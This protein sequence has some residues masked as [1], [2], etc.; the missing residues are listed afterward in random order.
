MSRIRY[1]GGKLTETVGGKYIMYADGNIEFH[2][3]KEIVFTGAEKGIRFG[4][5]KTYEY[6]HTEIIEVQFI[7]EKNKVLKKTALPKFGGITATNILYGKKIKIKI[8]TKEVKDGTRIMF[9]L[10]GETKSTHQPFLD[11]D[12]LKWK[13][14]IKNNTCETDFFILNPLWY[15]ED[16]EYYDYD[17]NTTKVKEED[18]NTFYVYGVLHAKVFEL[19][20]KNDRLTPVAYIRNYEELIGLFN[21][22]DLGGKDLVNNY[23]NKFISSSSKMLEI[24]RLFSA[25]ITGTKDLTIEQIETRVE[26][27]AKSIWNEA[28]K[29]VQAGKLDD[30]SLYWTR[31]KMQV[32]LKRHFL[33]E[34]DI[35]FEKSIV[36]KETALE[37]LIQVFEEKSRNYTG[38]DFSKAGGKKKVLITGFDPFL[39]NSIKYP[40]SYNILQSNPS[41]V[42]ALGLANNDKLGAYIQTIVVP[43]RY[44]DF[45][46]SQDN[47]KGQGEGIIERYITPFI[48]QV[49][50]IITISQAGVDDYHIDVFATA[51]RKGL[52]DNMDFKRVDESKSVSNTAPET[53]ITTLPIE[54]TRGNSKAIF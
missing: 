26:Q 49:D 3:L 1:I 52:N 11:I 39:L 32:R 4:E 23:E 24:A 29:Q 12:T 46:G 22:D 8:I 40:N 44:T 41:G 37:K 20:K 19:P 10:K 31:N 28:V 33:F 21:T 18:L 36:K 51:T 25:F 47:A 34:K 48:N 9:S 16:A 5:P 54:M 15:S 17:T 42:V 2:A 38:I 14:D 45:D 30:R 13:L 7:D 50:M 35:D 53:I 27:D 6:T 43:V